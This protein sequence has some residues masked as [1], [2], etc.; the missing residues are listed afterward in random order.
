MTF[1]QLLLS[2]YKKFRPFIRFKYW[3]VISTAVC[4]VISLWLAFQLRFDFDVPETSRI[5]SKPVVL[6]SVVAIKIGFLYL[7]R[8]HTLSWRHTGL[9]STVRVVLYA[10]SCAGAL[11]L[12][13][14]FRFAFGLPRGVILIDANLTMVWSGILVVG[15]RLIREIIMPRVTS[16]DGGSNKLKAVL[17]G[18]GDAGDLVLREITR[19]PNA[20]YDVSAIFDDN[21]NKKG[22]ILKGVRVVGAVIDIKAYAEKYKVDAIMIAIPS[23][24]RF[25]M[26][27]IYEKV[28]DLD[29]PVKTLPSLLEMVDETRPLISFRDINIQ[30]L[31]GREEIRIRYHKIDS[32]IAN[33]V[34]LVTG[35][36]G[37]IGSEICRQALNR[38][39]KKL[40]LLERSE[41]LLFHVHRNLAEKIAGQDAIKIIPLL[42]DCRD[43]DSVQRIFNKYKP[44]LVLHAAAHKHVPMQEMHPKECFRNNVGG[45]QTLIRVCNEYEV[46][47]FALISTDKAVNPVNVMGASKRAC[48]LYCLAHAAMIKTHVVAVRFGNVLGSEGSVVPIFLEQ[49]AAGGPVTV[50]HPEV[51]RYFMSIPEAVALVL[52]AAAIGKSGQLMMLD[53]GDPV[54]ILNLAKQLIF[55]AGKTEEEVG[56]KITGLRLGEKLFEE[57][58]CDWETCMPTD[59]H[60]IRIYKQDI[61]DPGGTIEQID[62]LVEASF[63]SGNGFDARA[64]LMEIVKEYRP[65]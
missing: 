46:E 23:A 64:A 39:P 61:A 45:I 34:V 26:K 44:S 51:T 7:F 19:N 49:I 13:Q 2:N 50:T 33:K 59:H 15:A 18:A 24:T 58:S 30:D 20:P 31:L 43:Y 48:E 28:R 21:P 52:Q 54:R 32:I 63:H 47:R 1:K 29:L 38:R 11:G 37:S 56:V 16:R 42:V 9:L 12:I 10:A 3:V 5:V 55:L 4:S 22:Y 14:H 65:A 41:N 17:V 35:A 57:L 6:A 36:G 60:K 27:T 8:F 25:Q 62:R 40:L 53:M